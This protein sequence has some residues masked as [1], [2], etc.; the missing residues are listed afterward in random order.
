M[1][2]AVQVVAMTVRVQHDAATGQRLGLRI[3]LRRHGRIVT[4]TE[5]GQSGDGAP[6]LYQSIWRT[7]SMTDS[8]AAT[9]QAC[10]Q[11]SCRKRA[12]ENPQISEPC[13][14]DPFSDRPALT[15]EDIAQPS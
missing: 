7:I 3:A 5:S 8:T 12:R 6:P 13:S 15:E 9:M 10:I 11:R 4:A 2:A 14:S 1:P